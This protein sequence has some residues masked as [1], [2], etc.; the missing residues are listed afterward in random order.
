VA[1]PKNNSVIRAF[2][3]L[4]A[5]DD[6]TPEMSAAEVAAKIGLNTATTHRFLL[7]LADVGAVARTAAGKFR[8]GMLLA[9]LGGRVMRTTVLADAAAE[10]IRAVAADVRETT[11]I[12][13]LTDNV[14]VAIAQAE[15]D[16]NLRIDTQVGRR[17]PAYCTGHGKALLAALDDRALAAFFAATPLDR[18]TPKTITTEAALRAELARIRGNG[19]SVG[20]EEAEI[21]LRSVSVPIVDTQDRVRAAIAVSGP[22]ARMTDVYISEI[23]P[24][25]KAAAAKIS[26]TLYPLETSGG[27]GDD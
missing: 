1:T 15:P 22:S 4:V 14:V 20:D 25:L 12:A 6:R 23:L 10:T 19:Y 18:K 27:A 21:G 2:R 8:L 24:R 11:H 13:I 3:I 5:F 26:R 7:T 9:D 17:L 16:R